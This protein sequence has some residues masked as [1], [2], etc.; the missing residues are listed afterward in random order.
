[1][2]LLP[3]PGQLSAR[4]FSAGRFS[5]AV[6]TQGRFFSAGTFQ[7]KDVF[8]AQ[9]HFSARAFQRKDVSAQGRFSATYVYSEKL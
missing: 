5:A 2:V 6:S 7:R 8:S 1:M 3:I 4:R 9:G